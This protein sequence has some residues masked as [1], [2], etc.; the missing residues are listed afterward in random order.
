MHILCNVFKQ[1]R[2]HLSLPL[3][4]YL[5]FPA[6]SL[7]TEVAAVNTCECPQ[8]FCLH[9]SIVT[10]VLLETIRVVVCTLLSNIT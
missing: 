1:F 7:A 8:T 6:H 5:W 2:R 9:P 4:S 10:P 3:V